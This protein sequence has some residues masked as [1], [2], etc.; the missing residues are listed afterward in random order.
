MFADS[1]LSIRTKAGFAMVFALLAAN[2]LLAE[3]RLSLRNVSDNL[4]LVGFANTDPV[5][6]IQFSVNGRGGI[7]F[8]A[9]EGTERTSGTGWQ[10]FQ[11]L[12]DDSTLNVVIL[13]P[14]RSSLPPGQGI[15]GRV[16]F[17][18]DRGISADTVRVFLSRTEICDAFAR[19]L[20]LITEQLTWSTRESVAAGSAHFTLEQNYPNPFNPS[21][22]IT[23]KLS[24]PA[25]VQ[26]VIYDI[27]GR[28]VRTLVSQQQ[29]EGQYSVKWN[30]V[31][32]EGAVLPSGMYIAR[33]KVS[34]EVATKKLLLMK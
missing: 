18:L 9:F 6:G 31:D 16:S 15:I 28:K 1:T 27:T 17:N 8:R 7:T 12:K 33:L 13:A 30:A 3:N 14:V 29:P 5:A 26:L 32:D 20:D 2:R 22:T 24:K 10:I 11:Y 19:I 34:Y 4:I 23:Y 21:T 25:Q